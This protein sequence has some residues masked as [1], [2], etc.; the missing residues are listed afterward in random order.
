[1]SLFY[2]EN[3]KLYHENV[4][5][6]EQ[7]QKFVD[8]IIKHLTY[9]WVKEKELFIK[10]T[11]S[12]IKKCMSFLNKLRVKPDVAPRDIVD[13][14]G[15]RIVCY[16]ETDVESV[17]TLLDGPFII[18]E[19]DDKSKKGGIDQSGYKS[20]HLRVQLPNDQDN[21]YMQIAKEEYEEFNTIIFE[22]QVRTVFQDAWAVLSH[23]KKYKFGGFVPLKLTSILDSFRTI[24]AQLD[25]QLDL[26]VKETIEINNRIP[27]V[28]K[29]IESK[30]PDVL[31]YIY[32]QNP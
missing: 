23:E 6:F 10:E 2:N 7:L 14:Y 32:T 18:L 28:I 26:V 12:R 25:E 31:H 8:E 16:T 22:I 4:E 17:Y 29:E 27:E 15:A 21:N 3:N 30:H 19:K 13:F 9:S 11:D 24:L 5:K 20:V 1:M